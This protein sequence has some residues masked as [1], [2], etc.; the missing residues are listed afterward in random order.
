[1]AD[2]RFRRDAEDWFKHIS[3]KPPL[4]T[5]FDLYYLCLMAGLAG[6]HSSQPQYAPGFVDHFI[7]EYRPVSHIIIGLLILAEMRRMGIELKDRHDM[8]RLVEKM[9]CPSGLSNEGVAKCDSYASGGYEL[10]VE[11]FTTPYSIEEF[12]P[13]YQGYLHE[14]SKENPMI[15][16]EDE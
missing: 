2:F 13:R 7:E 14:L 15:T 4:S 11:K 5:K 3:S 12:L 16:T 8:S 10:L 9:L 6:Q 1:M